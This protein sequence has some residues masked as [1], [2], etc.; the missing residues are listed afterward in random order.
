MKYRG[1]VVSKVVVGGLPSSGKSEVA[2]RISEKCGVAHLQVNTLVQE[3]MQEQSEFAEGVRA[4]HKEK[5]LENID[6]QRSAF[7]ETKK[8]KKGKETGEF[9]E[10][11]VQTRLSD[12]L[13]KKIFHRRLLM[14]D[15]RLKGYVL[16]GYP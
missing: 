16:D 1:L 8:K 15:C 14:N 3:V 6:E 4:T 10:A 2:Q 7:E 9:D 11:G 12:E 13:L 5:H